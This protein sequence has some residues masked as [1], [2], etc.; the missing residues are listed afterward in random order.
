MWCCT[1]T[2]SLPPESTQGRLPQRE[3]SRR[4]AAYEPVKAVAVGAGEKLHRMRRSG[5]LKPAQSASGGE[6]RGCCGFLKI[7]SYVA[8][9]AEK[10]NCFRHVCVRVWHAPENSDKT[11]HD[12]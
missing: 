1:L 3:V 4:A 8:S 6:E 9:H 5:A 11:I 12:R 7:A 10:M 2:S